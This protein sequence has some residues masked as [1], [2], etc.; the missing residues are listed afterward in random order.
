MKT[1]RFIEKD[2][3]G[4]VQDLIGSGRL[5][6]KEAGIAKRMLDKGY[7]TLS[8]KQKIVFYKAIENNMINKCQRCGCDIPW[9]EM[10]EALD[11]SGYCNYCQHI[12]EKFDKE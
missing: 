2:F 9:L 5:D 1:E 7:D 10:H 12:M 8:D 6:E 3:N 11:N 4:F